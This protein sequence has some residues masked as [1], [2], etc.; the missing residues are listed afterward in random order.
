LTDRTDRS[1]NGD[2]TFAID[3]TCG[4]RDG[5][6]V[7]FVDGMGKQLDQELTLSSTTQLRLSNF[8]PVAP[9]S[10]GRTDEI[11]TLFGSNPS[12]ATGTDY[13]PVQG[14]NYG[15][16]PTGYVQNQGTSMNA[17]N[18]IS[19]WNT[20]VGQTRFVLNSTVCGDCVIYAYDGETL[21]G[22]D[23]TVREVE[24]DAWY[25]EVWVWKGSGYNNTQCDFSWTNEPIFIIAI[26]DENANF[27]FSSGQK[28]HIQRHEMGHTI[29]LW[30]A[31]TGQSCWQWSVYWFPLMKNS[32]TNCSAYPANNVPTQNEA[33]YAKL[34]MGW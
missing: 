11:G 23:C 10:E 26:N 21:S 8:A 18:A 15:V 27:P 13:I 6:R 28:S 5:N 19:L 22:T 20:A 4:G 14:Y 25:A 33:D 31:D 16:T 29:R 17:S 24:S 2:L 3:T 34:W 7:T 30:D 12:L 1:I 32:S 9:H